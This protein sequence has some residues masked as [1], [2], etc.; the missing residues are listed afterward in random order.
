MKKR[1]LA[2]CAA[3]A[4][5]AATQAGAQTADPTLPA[6]EVK[7]TPSFPERNQIP[8]TSES[9]TSEQIEQTVNLVNV[10]DA[11]KYLP[12]LIVRK[13]NFGDQQ[14]PLA[15]RTSGL[16][17]SAR[18]LIYA[19]GVL[20]STLI[21]NNNG[22]ASPNW[23]MVSPEEI[24]R[25]DVMY[26]PFSA[27]YPG[28]SMGA[29]VQITTRMPEKFEASAKIL[30]AWQDY[31][32]YGTS[33]TYQT[34]QL[35]AL[36]GARQDGL[37]WRL[38]ASHLDAHSQPLA[39]TTALKPAAPSAAGTPVTGAYMD[40]NRLGQAIAVIGSGGIESKHTDNFKVKLAYD[41]TP[42]WQASY[43]LGVFQNDIHSN[44][45]TY[46]RN[47]A[48]QP[49][50]SGSVNIQGYNY[51]IPASS[52]S[53]S[54]GMYNWS[55]EHISQSLALK[56]DMKGAWDWEAVFS[57][58]DYS[59]DELR[60]P[61]LALPAGQNGG[62]G[63]ITSLGDTGWTTYDLKGT[64]RP[65][66]YAGPHQVG[67]GGHYD[68]YKLV[69][70]VYATSD[71][72]SGDPGARTTDSRGKTQTQALWAQDAWRFA[73]GLLLT[74]GARQEWWRASDGLNF[75]AAPASNVNQ[76]TLT[77]TKFSPK[78]SLAWEASRDW[79]V[80][81]SYG[82][83][84]RFPTVTELYQAV[85][86]GG[87][88]YTP[89]PNLRPEQAYSGELAL[90]R[91]F[92]RGRIRLSLFQEN[93]QDGLISQNSTIP[94]TNVIGSSVQNIDRIRS[95]GAEFVAQRS[96]ALVRGL[97]LTGSL[98]YVDSIIL[99]DPGF[100]NAAGVLTNVAGKY[101]PNIPKW[102]ATGVA[103]Y[104]YDDHLSGTVAARYSARVYATVDNTDVYTHTF[105]GFDS[106]F[107]VDARL[108]YNFDRQTRASIGVDNLNN[109]KYFLFHPFPQR[110]AFAELKHDF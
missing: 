76:P 83:A 4:A 60:V 20:L 10:E 103:T 64:W 67:F 81:G 52:F 46:L 89:N 7:G 37:S 19:D 88:V 22:T 85:T 24:E 44:V 34:Q 15:T 108:N 54:S 75:S 25:I 45:D 14:A 8:G 77:S 72:I 28:N 50:Y 79:L 62:A 3:A 47:A 98:T 56:S 65:Q 99:S 71:W 86:V 36:L 29:V 57:R 80:T 107:V 18:S 59:R 104:R 5:L 35:N 42:E 58:F 78:A 93:L 102:K 82:T 90:E 63:T 100:R 70:T 49:V 109:Q 61:G 95:R 106:F 23:S 97:D 101:T 41:F 31:S 43:T 87:V 53:S 40:S 105:Q 1:I 6:V 39:I 33:N 55:Q 94:G 96:D 2:G 91:A 66:G 16:G 32:L 12:S 17:Q 26:G 9:V 92:A 13:R 110:T 27:A 11:V 73:P 38:T 74:L 69:S 21:G 68:Q 30:G 84:Y 48:G 51:N